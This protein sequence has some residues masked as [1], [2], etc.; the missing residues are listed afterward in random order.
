MAIVS[1]RPSCLPFAVTATLA[2]VIASSAV[3]AGSERLGKTVVFSATYSGTAAT[4]V[5]GSVVD[6][7]ATGTGNG[8]LLGASKV[9]GNGTGNSA[10]PPCVPFTGPGVFT[11]T[12]GK[13][14]FTVLSGS[15]ACGDS[16]SN[17]Y[18]VSGTAKFAG[19]TGKYASATGTLKFKGTFTH[20][21]GA[22]KA[23]FTGSLTP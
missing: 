4:K 15:S 16:A 2:L 14:D 18:A 17:E 5:T 23:T 10:N 13:L 8:T 7:R 19:G 3:A 9:S 22:F 11:G 6:V 21:S 12:G 1:G 20:S